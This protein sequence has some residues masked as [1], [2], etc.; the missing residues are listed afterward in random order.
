MIDLD[1][2]S[3]SKHVTKVFDSTPLAQ[4]KI[5]V[6]LEFLL[7]V[8]TSLNIQAS[9]YFI[10]ASAPSR[11]RIAKAMNGGFEA[12]QVKIDTASHVIV[13]CTRMDV[14]REHLTKVFEREHADH[15]FPD[16]EQEQRW[17]EI[18][19]A[20]LDM[21]IHDK[22]DLSHWLEK[23]TYMALGMMMMAAAA[24]EVDA[25]PMEGFCAKALDAELGLRE[26]GLTST[27]LLALGKQD[28]ADWILKVLKSRLPR[29][30]TFT[31]LDDGDVR[32]SPG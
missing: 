5:D 9:H 21:H 23:Q 19:L 18:V 16:D 29:S 14:P 12:N 3:R 20:G 11:S 1:E 7:S 32:S 22:K 30:Q 8:P 2:L 4:S 10:A 27:V 13:F 25:T 15:K 28:P 24:V 26:R 6:L 31:F 17:R